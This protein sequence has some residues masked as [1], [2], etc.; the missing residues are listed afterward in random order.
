MAVVGVV[1]IRKRRRRRYNPNIRQVIGTKSV[2]GSR[3]RVQCKK[4]CVNDKRHGH[5]VIVSTKSAAL[6][7]KEVVGGYRGW[8]KGIG[9]TSL[10]GTMQGELSQR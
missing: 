6:D 3:W 8:G 2:Q 7:N 10:E 4:G 1:W 9:G 5:G